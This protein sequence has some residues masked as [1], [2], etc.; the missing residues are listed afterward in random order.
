MLFLAHN[1]TPLPHVAT[2][3]PLV[4]GAL[5][6]ASTTLIHALPLNTTVGMVRREK[7][8]GLEGIGWWTDFA[9]V[10]RVVSCALLAH[11]MEIAVWAGLFLMC[12][13]FHDFGMAYYH[14]AVNFTTLGY[15]DV[16][17]S[18]SWRLLG[19]LEAANGILLFGVSTA[20]VFAVIVRLMQARFADLKN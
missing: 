2:L 5:A 15:G 8:L 3:L 13:E 4:A 7:K 17:M 10:A 20:M 12:G 16:V 19:P 6:S 11:L 18:P 1:M 14:S 9:I